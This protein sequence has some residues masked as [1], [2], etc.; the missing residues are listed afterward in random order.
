MGPSS[1]L[2]GPDPRTTAAQLT[3]LALSHRTSWLQGF[4]SPRPEFI[5]SSPIPPSP[6]ERDKEERDGFLQRGWRRRRL[7]FW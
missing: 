3:L 4:Q 6:L 1:G 5:R 7:G 2:A